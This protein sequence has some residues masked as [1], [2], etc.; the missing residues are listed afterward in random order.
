MKESKPV[1]V[2]IDVSKAKLDVAILLK[3]GTTA[4]K[5]VKHETE[6]DIEVLIEF[7]TSRG[8]INK[9]PI[10]IESTGAYHWLSCV[11]LSEKGFLVHLINPLITKK[12]QRASIRGAKTDRIDA[13]RL[14][15]IGRLEKALPMF[16]DSRETLSKRR[17]QSLLAKV[18]KTKQQLSRAYADAMKAFETIGMEANL[19]FFED[20]L[21]Q[22]DECIKILKKTITQQSNSLA[23]KMAEE[24]K[25]L[26]LFQATVLTNSIEGKHFESKDQLIAFFG[27]DVKKRESGTWRGKEKLSKRG[28]AYY[29]KILFQL[30]WSLARN[31]EVFGEYYH[32]LYKENG[33][34]YYTALIATA[35]K[36]LRFFYACY[37]K[38]YQNN[39]QFPSNSFDSSL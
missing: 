4:F 35:R 7:L 11:V 24:I 16:F 31:N 39:Y 17:Y 18:E 34:H 10:V 25:G 22:L 23:Q 29:R 36:F 30:G 3:D 28:N 19:G 27:L 38:D 2:G 12:Y 21:L 15:E 20:T 26:S 9:T 13:Q 14:A 5:T 33:K 6:A 8:V 32:R 1:S 37:L